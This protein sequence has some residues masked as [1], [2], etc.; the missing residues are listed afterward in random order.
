[1]S[2][3]FSQ[4][5]LDSGEIHSGDTDVLQ[6]QGAQWPQMGLDLMKEFPHYLQSIQSLDVYLDELHDGRGWSI[7]GN[8]L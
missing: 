3:S 1:M 7:E 6:G 4:V 8:D 2:H 5:N